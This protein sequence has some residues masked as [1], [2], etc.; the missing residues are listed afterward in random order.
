MLL[1]DAMLVMCRQVS[2]LTADDVLSTGLPQS[3]WLVANHF[4]I[5]TFRLDITNFHVTFCGD[6]VGVYDPFS[7][8]GVTTSVTY[9][10]LPT[11]TYLH[12]PPPTLKRTCG[13]PLVT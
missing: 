10:P 5:V 3:L 1:S 6:A 9:L 7:L 4:F 11:F 2:T 8:P 12:L 13:T